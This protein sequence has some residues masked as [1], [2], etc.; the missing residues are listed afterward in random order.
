L[1]RTGNRVRRV[2]A[3]AYLDAGT[4]AMIFQMAI[5]AL[6]AAGFVIKTYWYRIKAFFRGSAEE[7]SGGDD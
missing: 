6:L 7:E 3:P 4:G 1:N 2:P 5:A